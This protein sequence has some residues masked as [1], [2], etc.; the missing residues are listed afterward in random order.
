MKQ[1][2]FVFINFL[3]LLFTSPV[4]TMAQGTTVVVGEA[5]PKPVNIVFIMT[6]DQGYGDIGETNN[7]APGHPDLV[8]TRMNQMRDWLETVGGEDY[9]KR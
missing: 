6:D 2:H 8:E 7:L 4:P 9:N 5:A 3:I 1:S